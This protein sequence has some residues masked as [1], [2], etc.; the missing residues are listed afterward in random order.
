[1]ILRYILQKTIIM[2]TICLLVGCSFNTIPP[3]VSEI[4]AQP[5][6]TIQ[7]GETASLTIP[8]SGTEL[9]FE[10]TVLRGS[11]SNPTQP[12]VIYTAPNTP[13][14][15]TVTVKV[16]NEG[17]TIIKSINFEVV[18]SPPTPT[19][20]ATNTPIP[21]DTPTPTATPEPIEC[22]NPSITKNVFPW[23]VDV[24]GQFPFY[25]PLEETKF[26]CEGVYDIV[27][28]APLAVHIK[29]TRAGKNFGF[30]GIGVKKGFD[31]FD[32]SGYSE[33]CFWAYTIKPD[34][35]FRLKLRELGTTDKG[36]VVTVDTANQWQEICTDL[37]EFA[38]MGVKLDNLENVN[39]GFE[40]D[41]D[42]T[43]V[44]VDDFELK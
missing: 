22:R 40:S 38:D 26:S 27:H 35:S 25:G 4:Q 37:N 7:T 32:V 14:F 44:W 20:T 11:L 16:S 23:L 29:F 1:M 19:P 6:T 36:I 41:I 3:A 28:S 12:A 9:T 43:E 10:W 15:D 5:S 17:G 31:G 30:W 42:S 21:T 13:G 8:V 34:Q 24:D 39:L 2:A 18:A 33:V